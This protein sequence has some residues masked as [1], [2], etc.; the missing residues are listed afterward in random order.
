MHFPQSV[1][2]K[3]LDKLRFLNWRKRMKSYIMW[4]KQREKLILEPLI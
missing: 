4:Y 1:L 3:M 2:D